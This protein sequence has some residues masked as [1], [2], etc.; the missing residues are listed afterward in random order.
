MDKNV[1]KFSAIVLREDDS[2]DCAAPMP[3]WALVLA[4]VGIVMVYAP[5]PKGL[6]HPVAQCRATREMGFL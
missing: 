1:S 6:I 4:C 5:K 2:S 3:D